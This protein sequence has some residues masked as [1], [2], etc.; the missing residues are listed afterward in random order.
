[1][2]ELHDLYFSPN[3]V[4]VMKSIKIRWACGADGRREACI[5]FWWET[6]KERGHWGN[7]GV[8]GMIY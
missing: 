5:G 1:M 2:Q 4:R 6:L 8:D 7:P 3:I